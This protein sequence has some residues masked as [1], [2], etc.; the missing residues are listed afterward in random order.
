MT[1]ILLWLINFQHGPEKVLTQRKII[2]S[3]VIQGNFLIY[4]WKIFQ[5]L[6]LKQLIKI[7]LADNKMTI[8]IKY[9]HWSKHIALFS[10]LLIYARTEI[11]TRA[12]QI[13]PWITNNISIHHQGGTAQE[14]H[15]NLSFKYC[16]N[17][18]FISTGL[19]PV[20]E[21]HLTYCRQF[22]TNN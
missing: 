4:P 5:Y 3:K 21:S 7:P 9:S 8:T 6:L 17:Y 1:K 19:E 10:H 20:R 13:V 14:V 18:R 12:A 15:R 11:N 16:F 22:S 2:E